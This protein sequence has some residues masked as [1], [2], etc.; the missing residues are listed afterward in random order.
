MEENW[1]RSTPRPTVKIKSG[2]FKL[3]TFC[4]FVCEYDVCICDLMGMALYFLGFD[5]HLN[6]TFYLN[7]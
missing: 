1:Y 3:P 2:F 6:G 7:R 5:T 4:L